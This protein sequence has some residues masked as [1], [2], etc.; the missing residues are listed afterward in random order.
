MHSTGPNSGTLLDLL[1]LRAEDQPHRT[2]YVFLNDGELD[3]TRLTYLQ[4]HQ[5]ARAIAA[6]LQSL[7]AV[8]ERV[9]MLYP[10]GL[11]FIEGFFGCIYAGSIAVPAYAPRLNRNQQRL[12]AIAEDSGAA[13]ILTTSSILTKIQNR[14]EF[15]R[16]HCI[17]SDQVIADTSLHW[18]PPGTRPESIA[19]LQY[20]S[21][22]TGTPKGV[23]LTHDNLLKNAEAQEEA[24]QGS[25][26]DIIVS[27]LP[28]FHDMGF[29]AGVI[30]PVAAEVCS[31]ALPST[32]FVQNPLRWLKAISRFKATVSGGP[33]FGFDLCVERI[34]EQEKAAL[35]LSRWRVAF[36]GAEPVQQ[37]T[38]ERFARAFTGCGFKREALFPCYGLAEATLM[39]S[40]KP[41]SSLPVYETVREKALENNRIEA[42]VSGEKNKTLVSSGTVLPGTEVRIVDPQSMM[43]CAPN[44]IGEIWVKGPG[45][46]EGYWNKP[47]ENARVFNGKLDGTEEK[48]LR[49]GDLGFMHGQELFVTGRL[50]DLII[51]RG[52]NHYPQDIEAAAA[53]SHMSLL[54]GCGAAFSVEIGSE[55][56]LVIVQEIDRSWRNGDLDLVVK[57]VRTAITDYFELQPY[58]IVL[59]SPGSICRTSSGKIQRHACKQEFIN[60]QLK[61]WKKWIHGGHASETQSSSS[62]TS[63]SDAQQSR[64]TDEIRN[65]LV[66]KVAGLLGVSAHEV[67]LSKPFAEYGLDSKDAVG[68][69]GQLEVFL[70]TRLPATL[71]Y[72]YPSIQSL[73]PRLLSQTSQATQ[74]NASH[75]ADAAREPLALVGM[76][77]R[78]PGANTLEKFW[79]LLRNG[80]DAVSEVPSDRWNANRFYETDPNISGKTN[81]RWG[82][83][84]REIELFDANF[85]GIS[86]GEAAFMDPQQRLLMET[87]WHAL[88]DAGLLKEKLTGSG[89]GTFIGISNNEYGNLFA[90]DFNRIGPYLATGNSFSIAANRMA[91]HFDWRGPSMAVDTACSSSLVAV[92]L[93][94]KALWNGEADIAVAGGANLILS[95]AL[96]INFSK[97]GV[98]SPTGR[99]RSFDSQADGF[100]RSEGIGLVVLKPLASALADGDRIY[101]VVRGSAVNQDGRSN[102]LMAPNCNAQVDLLL[103]AYRRAGVAPGSVQLIE[104]HGSG[105]LLGDSIELEAL[106]QVFP[107]NGNSVPHYLGSVKSNIGHAE[108][109][110]GVAGLIKA[111]LSLYHG[112]IPPSIHFHKSNPYTQPEQFNATV[113]TRLLP[114]P[115]DG[116]RFAGVSSFGFGGTNAHV[117]LEKQ[118][119]S[120]SQKSETVVAPET[121]VLPISANSAASLRMQVKAYGELLA[122]KKE[123][124]GDICFT[125]ATRRTHHRHRVMFLGANSDELAQQCEKFL[126]QKGETARFHPNRQRLR[127]AFVFPGHGSQWPGMGRQLLHHTPFLAVIEQCEKEM[128]KHVDWSLLE[129]LRDNTGA[130]LADIDVIQPALFAVQL[131][132]VTL[133]R[134][135]GIEPDAVIGQSMGEIL[136][137]HVSGAISFS[138]AV[139]MVC[140][141]S[142]LLKKITDRGGMLMTSLSF[143][144]A[145]KLLEQEQYR[146]RISIG[147]SSS[148]VS[149]VLSG[150][151]QALAETEEELRSRNIFCRTVNIDYASHSAKV[152]PIRDEFIHGLAG[153][154]PGKGSLPIYSTVTG[155]LAE[156]VRWDNEYWWRNLREPVLVADAMAALLK[157]GIEAFIEISPHPV[158]SMSIM[159]SLQFYKQNALVVASL[160]RDRPEWP[161]LL[162]SVAT[163][164]TAGDILHWEGIVASGKHISLPPYAFDRKRFW[165]DPENTEIAPDQI[166]GM[167]SAMKGNGVVMKDAQRGAAV[168]AGLPLRQDAGVS[169]KQA[170]LT[171][172]RVMVAELL[173]GSPDDLDVHAPFLEMGADSIILMNALGAL[174]NKYGVQLSIRDLFEGYTTLDALA[175]YILVNSTQV[176]QSDSAVSGSAS[177]KT[178]AQQPQLKMKVQHETNNAHAAVMQPVAAMPASHVA[179]NLE[180][181]FNEQLALVSRVIFGQ[182]QVLGAA[183][184]AAG[185]AGRTLPESNSAATPQSLEAEKS[186]PNI[187]LAIPKPS[188]EN[189]PARFVPYAPLQPGKI[190]GISR[191]QQQHL[192]TF[193][194]RYTAKTK[195]SKE[196]T[197]KYRKVLADN[198]AS[199]GFR[200]SIKE[201]LYPIQAERS[202]GANI[203]DID[204]NQYIDLT[205]GFGV[206]LFGHSA[207]FLVEA[208]NKQ[209]AL[210]VQL[211]PQSNLAGEVAEAITQFTGM[212]R[213]TFTNS[214]TE[215]V[216]M[217]VRI[218]RTATKRAK[219]AIFS[220]SYHGTYDGVIARPEENHPSQ[221][222]PLAP[223]ILPGAVEEV[224]VLEY[225]DPSALVMIE[226]HATDLA[227][228]L[229]EPVQSRR[230]DWQ[231]VAFL[232]QLRILTQEH[233]IALIFDEV[234]TGFRMAPGGAQELFGVRADLAT[235]GKVLGGGMPIGVVAGHSRYMDAI[236]GGFWAYGDM[237]YPQA[238]TTFFAGTFCKHPLAMA[239][240]RAVLRRLKQDG[241][242]LQQRLNE[243]TAELAATLN[244]FFE[245]ESVPIKVVRCG[246]L[247]RFA[248]SGNMD[249]LF[250]HL[251]EKGIYIWEGRNLFLSTAHTE[252]DIELIVR[253][254]KESCFELR[255]GGFLPP[256]NKTEVHESRVSEAPLQN[257]QSS[258]RET[259]R[260]DHDT[261]R[262][263]LLETQK[264][265]WLLSEINPEASQAYQVSGALELNGDLRVEK[266]KQALATVAARHDILRAKVHSGGDRWETTPAKIDLRVIDISGASDLEQSDKLRSA[267]LEQNGIAFDLA[268]GPLIR[269]AL[270]QQSSQ[271]SV[272]M[273]TAHHIAVDGISMAILIAEIGESYS[274]LCKGEPASLAPAVQFTRY[275]QEH[276][277]KADSTEFALA[278]AFWLKQFEKLPPPLN[279][280][281]DNVRPAMKAYHGEQHNALIDPDVYRTLREVGGRYRCTPFMVFFAAFSAFLHRLSGQDEL[282]VG[283]PVADR[284]NETKS[285]VGYCTNVLP[286]LSRLATQDTFIHFL[287]RTRS[288][289]LDAFEHRDYPFSRLIKKLNLSKDTSHLPLVDVV[290]NL[291]RDP[292]LKPWHGLNVRPLS[293]PLAAV[294]F[295]LELNLV[296]SPTGVI[297]E[298][299]CNRDMFSE[300]TMHSMLQN[301][302][303]FLRSIAEHPE[304][305]TAELEALSDQ[306]R[307]KVLLQWNET[308][309]RYPA[310]RCVHEVIEE[311]AKRNPQATALK[312]EAQVLSYSELNARAN[313]LAHYLVA[314]NI[315]PECRVG[316]C[317][318]RS[319]E[320]VVAILGIL[321]AGAAY[322]PFDPDYPVERL[323]EMQQD[324]KAA[325]VL[326]QGKF[327]HR[328]SV[329]NAVA[330]E[331][332]WQEISKCE[333]QNPAVLL[334]PENLAYVIFTSGS[335]GR[336]K[337][338]MNTHGAIYNRLLWMQQE[339]SLGPQDRVLQK[340]PF[341]FDVS[342]WEFLW[343]L[344]TGAELIV[345]SP[346]G[347][348]DPSYLQGQIEH[349]KVTTIHFVPSMLAAFVKHCN[350]NRCSSLRRIICSGEALS[351]ELAKEC[352]EKFP[353]ELHNLY[354]PTEVAVD[355]THWMCHKER[356]NAGV[357][358]GQPIANTQMYVLDPRMNPMPVGVQG[359]LYIGGTGVGRGYLE[360]ADLTAER[361]VPDPFS[362]KAG[363][364]LYRTGD[365]ARWRHDGNLD[366]QGRIDHQVKLRGFRIELGDIEAGLLKHPGVAQAAVVVREDEPGQ[367]QLV[368]YFVPVRDESITA[369][370]L[371]VYLQTKLPGYMVPGAYMQL[372]SLP[373]TASGKLDRKRLPKPEWQSLEQTY[374]AP[375]NQVEELLAKVWSAVLK[376]DRVGVEDN[377][378]DLGGD[379]ILSL[380]IVARAHDEGIHINVQ[381]MFEFHTIA[382]LAAQ[383]KTTA[384][385]VVTD[386][387]PAKDDVELTPVQHWFFQEVTVDRSHWNQSVLLKPPIAVTPEIVE[388]ALQ[389]IVEKHDALRLKFIAESGGRWRQSYEPWQP[390]SP[391]FERIDLRQ[392]VEERA[393]QVQMQ[394]HASRCQ[395]GLALDSG[396]LLKAAWFDLGG[397][398]R[399]LLLVIHHLA[400]DAVSWRILLEDLDRLCRQQ[401]E[402]R[403]MRLAPRSSSFGEWSEALIQYAS[404]TELLEQL[405]Y[406][407]Q[408]IDVPAAKL[409]KDLQGSNTIEFSAVVTL[410]LPGEETR[411]LLQL[412]KTLHAHIH[413]ALPTALARAV[414]T[415]T[416]REGLLL[417]LEGHGRGQ[418]GEHTSKI[419]LSR[420]VGWFTSIYPVY[421]RVLGRSVGED[422]KAVKE[423]L[424]AVPQ[425]GA[426]FGVLRYLHAEAQSRLAAIP[427]AEILFNYLGQLDSPRGADGWQVLSET[428]GHERSSRQNRTHLLEIDAYINDGQLSLRFEFSRQIFHEN[429]VATFATRFLNE[430]RNVTN[431]SHSGDPNYSPSD[432]PLIRMTQQELDEIAAR[433]AIE[434]IYPLSPLQHG[435]LLHTLRA[436]DSGLYVNQ[437]CV[438]VEG[439]LDTERFAAAWQEVIARHSILRTGFE[440]ADMDEPVQI[441]ALESRLEWIYRDDRNLNKAEQAE[442]LHAFLT[443]DRKRSFDLRRPPLM[444]LALIQTA[445]TI[446]QVI[447][448][449][450]HLLLDGWS[451]PILWTEVLEIYR[452]KLEGTP[453]RMANTHPYR[454]Y[455]AW[456]HDQNQKPAEEFWRGL[457]KGFDSPTKLPLEAERKRGSGGPTSE[458]VNRLRRV[459]PKSMSN[460]LK[461]LAQK[462][463]ITVNCLA[464]ASWGILLARYNGEKD[465]VFGA[466]SNG[467]P[468]ELPGAET[469]VGLFINTLPVRLQLDADESA[470]EFLKKLQAQQ[471]EAWR[472]QYSSLVQ[473]QGWSAVPRTEALFQSVLVFENYPVDAALRA[474]TKHLSV[475]GFKSKEAT[476]YPLSALAVA[477]EDLTLQLSYDQNSFDTSMVERLLDHWERILENIA[478]APEKKVTEFELLSPQE[479]GQLIYSINQTQRS[480]P[481]R[482]VQQAFEEQS[483]RTPDATAVACE[484]TRLSYA[485]LNHRAN[486]LAHHLREMGV[487]EETTVA[488]CL[489]RSVELVV[490]VLGVLKSGGAYVPLEPEHPA[491]RASYMLQDTN[492]VVLISQESLRASLPATRARLICIDNEYEQIAQRSHNNPELRSGPENLAYV[493]YTS[494]STGK[495]K[496]VAIE[497]RQLYNYVKAVT[498]RIGIEKCGFAMVQPLTVDSSVTA[499]YT[500]LL[501]GG[502]VYVVPR[503]RALDASEMKKLFDGNPIDG[504]KIAPS[505]LAALHAAGESIMPGRVLV[506]GGESSQWNWM[507]QLQE[508]A[509]G[510]TV[511]NHYGP[512]ETTVGVLSYKLG[513]E[514]DSSQYGTSPLGNPLANTTV[515]ILDNAGNP[516]L[517][518]ETGEIYIGGKNVGRGYVNRTELTAEKFV[519]DA[520]SGEPGARLYRTGDRGRWLPDLRLEF[521]GRFDDQIKV[522]GFR[523]EPGEIEAALLE[524]AA[525]AQAVVIAKKD[526]GGQ[527][528]IFAYVVAKP[529]EALEVEAVRQYAK[530]CLPEYMMPR[531]IVVLPD[532]PRTTHGKLDRN[533]LP[534]PAENEIQAEYTP[535]QT[536][537]E[538]LLVRMWEQ[539]LQVT[540][541]GVNDNFFELGG[542]SLL[543][544]QVISRVRKT[545]GTD[546][547]LA[548][549]F[550]KPTVRTL[551]AAI[552]E[553]QAVQAPTDA[554]ASSM[555]IKKIVWPEQELLNRVD[556]MS[557]EELDLL[558][559]EMSSQGSDSQN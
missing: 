241:P 375:R 27:W 392:E 237:S 122:L 386:R 284:S 229:V 266:L 315:G 40:V 432:F 83:F 253:A 470:L 231:P 258:I 23:M 459:L 87:T 469:M 293:V 496:G 457:L 10:P 273:L 509:P 487:R 37:A 323:Q 172:L 275:I 501:C 515:Y 176:P 449:H 158:L 372:A 328:C 281:A 14:P 260:E 462:E 332:E 491:E 99:C 482:T 184:A 17:D 42:G 407:E 480:Y 41:A 283:I 271:S 310:G 34:T 488:L 135:F 300:Q 257:T 88:E 397:G 160:C 485:E 298:M 108:S 313:Q 265:I 175:D 490:A 417:D 343:P 339:Y 206:N 247:F 547:P 81:S 544:T 57:N 288:T 28:M 84:L 330:I 518:G 468:S 404:S 15:N 244:M 162:G 267:M 219:V 224:L 551:A 505:H 272:L 365:L 483:A 366:F 193:A 138:D 153:L 249:L 155:Q 378:F 261:Q 179:G 302:S 385:N 218:A 233:G 92:H 393:E 419:D 93:A 557:E 38:L 519:P 549:L 479:K 7:N 97:A 423:Q 354:G 376:K 303:A 30:Q 243:K 382:A 270:F 268:Q 147:I 474:G 439:T 418:L 59:I 364:R 317:M 150:E 173:Q 533:A 65:W 212:E 269:A 278:E 316:I 141:R 466:T 75:H 336:P 3:E 236:D 535:P 164:Y 356:L 235:Y 454:E 555:V 213:V 111:A 326:A 371:R 327:M 394:A 112:E 72:E 58:S 157:D 425:R 384:E 205:M 458:T 52:T 415:V 542:H 307:Q 408:L 526:K 434:D 36:N 537:E 534:I 391:V 363:S 503:E 220:G 82:G 504:L 54:A 105:T 55:E 187:Q 31:V 346:G 8:G 464:Q 530:Q 199:A 44:A 427:H 47:E 98:L 183:K 287:E 428:L 45:I 381:Q 79:Q 344:M 221:S 383:A 242:A 411:A 412:P 285:V 422:L 194:A 463:R 127:H 174:R 498:E 499:L 163:L 113:P 123:N 456:M 355:V 523:I 453:V 5:K 373:L 64:S 4:L 80:V 314:K 252:K 188:D 489:H 304:W 149:T 131:G 421:L 297:A 145:G 424:R 484:G 338:A 492:A 277:R 553:L 435:I 548:A 379:S 96:A 367:K 200:Y 228:V 156:N 24:L 133:W 342:V 405:P 399:R 472:Y 380:Q 348:H 299:Q 165:L 292:G 85:F 450:H 536:P 516:V 62:T 369:Q 396:N 306:E 190:G 95:P 125:A 401:V 1:Q 541:V 26:A 337:G 451:V 181:L 136:A 494:G 430:V 143:S 321:K 100:V 262:V 387:G 170:L 11:D 19:C 527:S 73:I 309:C 109:A 33:N 152:D 254:V 230:P 276:E 140:L 514:S 20:T 13:F 248:F 361:F 208:L 400:V 331:N 486:Q 178:T 168:Q 279:L 368:A 16:L 403:E 12:S 441:V 481:D 345:A 56:R 558:I 446:F 426:G 478:N 90:R 116:P 177:E 48:F 167:I 388:F 222:V 305:Q 78:F 374:V 211:G 204:G 118:Q 448:T 311:Q 447:W 76:A 197:Q 433:R 291:D 66:E 351:E 438:E 398:R 132:L 294:I 255:Q 22:S 497:N 94:C 161:S 148:P 550:E 29:M 35:D 129:L 554:A 349:H 552:I 461:Q 556:E 18:Q 9:L 517:R 444:R 529:G 290:F 21:G 119:G 246:S 467:R 134:S 110:A 289:L 416:G 282:V 264:Q 520:F 209:L 166:A 39:V 341:S 117:V 358:I 532:L 159:E 506:I 477:A 182:L 312:F 180:Q 274:G 522:R 521:L 301:Y 226:Q 436:P 198:R 215:A 259:K 107:A 207:P 171:D 442:T 146:H 545:F 546:V 539:L 528:R 63:V 70:G 318:E 350:M 429:T 263:P 53:A 46:G 77:C 60:D 493:L 357:C 128:R 43:P 352:L 511:I 71:L 502:C 234:I 139:L 104:A 443:A 420:T 250:Y 32:A 370:E 124:V 6:K 543:A 151:Q 74:R 389:A 225:G 103:E 169:R 333:T 440:W 238:M 68:L 460:K 538:E 223:G 239:S 101:C 186:H 251:L 406:W 102:G 473:I 195:K 286:V 114:W 353:A 227:A 240:T 308:S 191:Q 559:A 324:S 25:R 360:K 390:S 359:E 216:M 410:N 500:P 115:A 334:Q 121:H 130:S 203:W 495:P 217:A 192:E 452:A 154:Q 126:Q 510:C 513:E 413:E 445:E 196:L 329:L 540:R 2:G 524:C 137:A 106:R 455:I 256:A 295:D 471:A 531:A 201:M 414:K 508:T 91:Y 296:D 245:H 395:C 320:M 507:K 475:R 185:V 347:H 280:P 340:T 319:V 144:E 377:F 202:E 189:A 437:Q 402:G 61:V 210:G 512:T 431:Y 232:K 409:E 86:P 476:N 142:K 89:V 69:S 49:T 67:D 120:Q 50:K 525:V 51:I 214:G 322:V 362:K 465:V 325:I 335:T